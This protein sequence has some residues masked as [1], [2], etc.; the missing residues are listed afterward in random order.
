[1]KNSAW[2]TTR[3]SSGPRALRSLVHKS[4]ATRKSP[5]PDIVCTR[6]V[7]DGVGVVARRLAR[8]FA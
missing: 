4:P 6:E 1:M 3:G 2:S 8:D 5:E 7:G